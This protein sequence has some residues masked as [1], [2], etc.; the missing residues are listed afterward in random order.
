MNNIGILIP[1]QY[2][3]LS[4]AAIL[5]VLETAN[6]FQLDNQDKKS[7]E[8]TLITL[9][10]C[11][12]GFFKSYRTENIN[13]DIK[14]D[15]ILVPSFTTENIQATISLNKAFIPWLIKQYNTK[16]EIATFCTGAFLLA[17]TGLLDGKVATTHV[18][19]CAAFSAAFPRVRLKP[20]KTVTQDGQLYT[21]GGATSTF[22][23]LLYLLQI[24]CGKELAIKTAK[25]FAI[26]MDRSNQ[27]Y[28]SSFQP[29]RH[30]NDD[31]VASAQD[32]IESNYQDVST[33]EEMIKDIPSSR[34]NIVRRFK[35]VIGITPIEYLQ[36]T[37]IEAA[38]KLLEQTTQQMTE[39][40]YNSGYNDPKAFRK[41]FRK[42]V[43]MTPS[44]Y[45]DKF[46]VR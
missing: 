11:I 42:T 33:I 3:L 5:E 21:S 12:D 38:K 6:K 44:Q 32:K 1:E 20:D 9:D 43:G 24:H 7:F 27:S 46:Q 8:I 36:Q 18:D 17:A 40:I 31:I 19:A 14:Y 10:N 25:I 30:H 13:S 26:D 41:I 37:R 34:R 22:H 23:L 35:Q 2:K 29:S 28:F 45:R 16:T 15:L 39:I 4:V